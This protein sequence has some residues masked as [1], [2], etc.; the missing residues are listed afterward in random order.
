MRL[1]RK[2][3][4]RDNQYRER[5]AEATAALVESH[6]SLVRADKTAVQT[7]LIARR[8]KQEL[9][10]NHFAPALAEA[11]ARSIR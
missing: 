1:T 5:L 8:L 3:S 10:N 9:H 2:R 6:E 7:E 11:I 4:D